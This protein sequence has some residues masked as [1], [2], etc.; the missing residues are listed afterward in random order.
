MTI[1]IYDSG[2]GGLSVW[3]E[4]RRQV[5]A[6]LIYFGDTAHLPYGDKSP[7]Q[8]MD[9]FRASLAFLESRG[10]TGLV[11]ACNTTSSVVLPRIKHLVK[12]P[13]VGMIEGAVE[14][15][16][17]VT[18]GCIGVLATQATTASGVYQ[19]AF[20]DVLPHGQVFVQSAPGLVPLVEEGQVS[21][22]R[23]RQA[24]Q[25]YLEPL[26]ARGID[27]LLLG[28]THYSFLME[29]ITELLDGKIQIIDPA[30]AVAGEAK[31]ALAGIGGQGGTTEFWV[32]A[33]PERFKATAELILQEELPP[34]YLKE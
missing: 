10:C 5:S 4:L 3:R 12:L 24:L 30:S 23:A 22:Q 26:T 27:T 2:L 17:A 8:L 21:G 19:R 32:S 16:S 33:Q 9:Y 18:K 1:G 7:D 14:A 28:C 13:L 25:S 20:Q 31:A 15:A 6:P 11:V 29:L 34:V